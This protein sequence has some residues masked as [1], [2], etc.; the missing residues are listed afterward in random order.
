MRLLGTGLLLVLTTRLCYLVLR[1]Q[2]PDGVVKRPH[3][4]S[5]ALLLAAAGLAVRF[6]T[7]RPILPAASPTRLALIVWPALAAG[8]LA[9]YWP[10]LRVGLL[11][12]D[13]IL[14]QHAQAWDVSQ[15]APQLFR[16]LPIFVWAIVVHLG[17]GAA[18]L[19][20]LNIVLHATNAYLAGQL[21]AGWVAGRWW[22]LLASLLVLAA[23]LGPEAVAWC[24]GTFDVFATLCAMLAVLLTR[25]A[26]PAP[27]NRLLLIAVSIAALLS[28]ETA[29]ILPLLLL[30]DGAVRR[31]LTRRFIVDIVMVTA[32]AVVFG[33]IRVQ[34]ATAVETSGFSR[35]RVQ[36]LLFDSFGA[37][38]APWHVNDPSLTV[39]RTGYALCVIVLITAFFVNRG[40][41]WASAALLGGTCWVLASIL[42]LLAFF[43]VGPQLEGARYLYLAACGW[44]AILVVAAAD[45]AGRFPR[46]DALLRGVLVALIA[47][48]AWGV[49][50]HVRPWTHAAAV[51]DTVLRAAAADTRLHACSPAYVEG[52]PDSVD[53]AYL[54][55]NGAREA[56]A[57]V[58]VT[59]FARPDSGEC[60]FRW[61]PTAAKFQLR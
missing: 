9:L 49:R 55:A 22:P 25:Q 29:V 12:D 61:D 4:E 14:F 21:V 40:A 42:P 44:A 58:G 19:H 34:S 2:G 17:G 38:A 45:I 57:D 7:D 32:L 6:A 35:Y 50:Q 51:R 43:Y 5:A 33:A 41:R 39:V 56:L 48:G 31:S 13:F 47:M 60:A 23:P 24:A 20:L 3:L 1:Y 46:A 59:A 37:L 18:A 28:K 30:I 16:P 52:L 26:T 54:F 10:A 8:A 11:S 15:V 53:G 36:R 27:R